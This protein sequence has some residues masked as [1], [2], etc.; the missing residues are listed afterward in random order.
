M[1][2]PAAHRLRGRIVKPINNSVVFD[3]LTHKTPEFAAHG[4]VRVATG[5]LEGLFLVFGNVKLD[6]DG[7]FIKHY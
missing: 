6:C 4:R 5:P 2:I 7:I 3:V 1:T